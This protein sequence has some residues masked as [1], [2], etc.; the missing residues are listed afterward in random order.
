[1][2]LRIVSIVMVAAALAFSPAGA[3]GAAPFREHVTGSDTDAD[4]CGTGG[5]VD[6]SWDGVNN[7]W[8]GPN[9]SETST[10]QVKT[11]YTNPGN[12]KSVVVS[13]SGPLWVTRVDD[14]GGGY[15]YVVSF[16]GQ[17]EK[18]QASGPGKPILSKDAGYLTFYD[19]FDSGDNYLGTTVVEHWQHPEADSNF[20]VFCQVVPAALGL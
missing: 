15:T 13:S 8:L 19:H 12:G 16:R 9:S 14:A 20:Q 17:Q 5:T 18:I 2:K 6:I 1:M 10:G 3:L 11:T 7:L 4:F